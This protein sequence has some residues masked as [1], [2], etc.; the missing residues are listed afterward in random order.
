MN[1][2]KAEQELG[3]PINKEAIE[4]MEAN[5]VRVCDVNGVDV[6]TLF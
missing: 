1:L 6:L 5:L 4:Q 2:A 3:L